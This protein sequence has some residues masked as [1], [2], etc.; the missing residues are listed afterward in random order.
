MHDEPLS[1]RDFSKSLLGTV[2]ALSSVPGLLQGCASLPAA[3]SAQ[4]TPPYPARRQAELSAP[5]FSRWRD[6]AHRARLAP[7]PHNTQPFRIRPLDAGTADIVA[8][9]ERFLPEEDHGNRYVASAFGILSAATEMAAEDLGLRVIVVPAPSVDVAAL[10]RAAEPQTLGRAIIV[11]DAE[12]SGGG[13]LL[14]VRRTSRI[15][16]HDR[17]IEPE[18][19][20]AMQRIAESRG[21]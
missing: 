13:R 19:W 6:V 10:H 20:T 4:P 12:P 8:L 16:Y 21:D 1:R 2:A 3:A 7:T 15:P 11:G 9:G 5:E 18:V 17:I 14:D